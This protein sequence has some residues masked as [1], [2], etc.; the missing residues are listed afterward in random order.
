MQTKDIEKLLD[1][2]RA[3]TCTPEEQAFVESWY[4][5]YEDSPVHKITETERI[6]DLDEVWNN[7]SVMQRKKKISIWP[8]IAAAA[9]LIISVS[10]GLLLYV[11]QKN[12]NQELL[13]H[14]VKPGRNKAILTLANGKKINLNDAIN[15]ELVTQPGIRITKTA[16]GQ[17]VY[18][19][20]S[21][22]APETALNTI[23]VPVGGQWQVKLPDGSLVFL[24]ASSTL[25]YPTRF[26]DN[27]RKVSLNGEAYFEI[28][29]NSAMPF[30][31]ESSGQTV[32]VLGTHF[33][34]MAYANEPY[35]T[36]L[37][38]GSVK[39]SGANAA[40]ILRPGEQALLDGQSLTVKT[41]DVEEAL[42]WKNGYFK[43]N[44]SLKNIMNKISR[45]YDVEVVYDGNVDQ[46]MGF[47]GEIS[48]N[49][50]LSSVLKIMEMGGKVHFK[51][52]RRRVIVML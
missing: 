35:K 6:A 36:T 1:N 11:K 29:H 42:A 37:V 19:A 48:R 3:G 51:I 13:V 50:N 39:I 17:I 28:T 5:S 14:D 34:V 44:E 18:D 16:D 32:E 2:Y 49:K 7:L 22:T 45:W 12:N 24:N 47:G 9:V 20:S 4:L 15:G 31:V 10:V 46:N 38:E 23:E 30:K 21:A 43:F 33:N 41:A 40:K 26:K 25:T 8:R 52:E 27:E